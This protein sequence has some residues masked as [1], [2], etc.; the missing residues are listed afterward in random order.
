MGIRMPGN[1]ETIRV[2]SRVKTDFR[3]IKHKLIASLD[4]D[5]SDDAILEHLINFYKK[6][7]T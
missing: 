7:A 1:L 4:Q 3:K 6:H 2:S 5:L